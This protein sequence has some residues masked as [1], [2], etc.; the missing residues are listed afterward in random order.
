[1]AWVL[2]PLPHHPVASHASPHWLSPADLQSELDPQLEPS[3]AWF[4]SLTTL[5]LGKSASRQSQGAKTVHP[6]LGSLHFA[7]P[8]A[9]LL[10]LALHLEHLPVTHS[11]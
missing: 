10:Q 6:C 5:S 11:I 4:L 8:I 7:L 9:S 3:Q 2:S 1:M